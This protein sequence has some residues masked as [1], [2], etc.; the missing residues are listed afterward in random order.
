MRFPSC[1]NPANDK[2]LESR[3]SRFDFQFPLAGTEAKSVLNRRLRL[4]IVGQK[5]TTLERN[6]TGPETVGLSDIKHYRR[7]LGALF[8]AITAAVGTGLRT[9]LSPGC[10]PESLSSH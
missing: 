3:P 8:L 1:S 10:D 7:R 6:G 2:A 9:P 5:L 4:V